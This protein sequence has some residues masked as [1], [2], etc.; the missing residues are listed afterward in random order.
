[1][2]RNPASTP[3]PA[4]IAQQQ[5]EIYQLRLQGLTVRQIATQ[6]GM[7]RST[8]QNRLDSEITGRVLPVADEVRL[9]EVDRLDAWLARLENRLEQGEDPVRVVPVLLK[10]Q[11]RRARLLGLDA[12]ERADVTVHQ[13]D[14][15][16]IELREL[17]DEARAK[18]A[19]EEAE[20]QRGDQQ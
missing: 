10:V 9:L 20:L 18:Q 12:P 16:D 2:A 11:E 14:A 7:P 6:I 15:E 8:V 4:K 3:N 17:I 1:M 19:A 13:V 5:E